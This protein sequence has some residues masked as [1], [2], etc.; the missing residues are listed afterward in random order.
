[1]KTA[2]RSSS[3]NGPQLIGCLL[4]ICLLFA[5][6]PVA[7]SQTV[8]PMINY[9]GRLVDSNGVPLATGDYELTFN[10]YDAASAGSNIWG[11]QVLDG[12]PGAGHGAKVPVVQGY[13]NSILG[14]SDTAGRAIGDAFNGATRYLEIRVG[15]NPPILPRQQILTAPYAFAS[16]RVA[17][18]AI[19][20]A[21]LSPEVLAR[22]IPHKIGTATRTG[23]EES[24]TQMIPHELGQVPKFVRITALA[25][26]GVIESFGTYDGSTTA[27]IFA[28]RTTNAG[29]PTSG[30]TSDRIIYLLKGGSPSSEQSASISVDSTNIVL[31]WTKVLTGVDTTIQILWEAY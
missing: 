6:A 30:N 28:S 3:L 16:A 29:T 23:G 7:F 22:V 12:Q 24:G 19:T 31:T 1:M 15:T 8:P 13:F 14:P 4:S 9:Q 27:T 21:M 10:I 26:H 20:L 17:N 25:N 11:P 5:A 2:S 18:G